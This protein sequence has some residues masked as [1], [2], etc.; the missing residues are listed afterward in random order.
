MSVLYTVDEA[1]RGQS[2]PQSDVIEFAVY[3]LNTNLLVFNVHCLA[4]LPYT[5]VY[6]SLSP[7]HLST[8]PSPPQPPVMMSL[9]VKYSYCY[10][11]DSRR[12]GAHEVVEVVF[13]D[14]P[15]Y[16]NIMAEPQE[17]DY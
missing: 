10:H 2:V 11:S 1:L 15:L 8:P 3:T 12:Q 5:S 16:S 7:I 6:S 4:A 9:H 14:P 13:R 17:P